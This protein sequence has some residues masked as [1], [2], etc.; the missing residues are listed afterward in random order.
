MM[1]I[2]Y[3]MMYK[4]PTKKNLLPTN[5]RQTI[6]NPYNLMPKEM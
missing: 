1:D 5:S 4:K 2:D 3:E 6:K